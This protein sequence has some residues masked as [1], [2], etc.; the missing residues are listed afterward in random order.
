LL[1]QPC[2]SFVKNSVQFG[3]AKRQ[4]HVQTCAPM[5]RM[6]AAGHPRGSRRCDLPRG[7]RPSN[8]VTLP[9]R[10]RPPAVVWT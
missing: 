2:V 6:T 10:R 3:A 4:C 5:R 8:G 1:D 9:I 7:A